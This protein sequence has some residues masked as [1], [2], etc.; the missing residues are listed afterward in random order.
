MA[1]TGTTS[2]PRTPRAAI[3]AETGEQ[4][5]TGLFGGS[6]RPT[7]G[8]GAAGKRVAEDMSA[9]VEAHVA[10][11]KAELQ[12]GIK[13]KGAGAGAFG[14]AGAMGWLGLQ[15]LFITLGFVLAIWLQAWAA[16][17]IVTG[18][19]LLLAGMAALVGR[20][21]MRTPVSLDQT[22]A[23]LTEDVAVVK[24]HLP[25]GGSSGSGGAA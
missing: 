20:A 17:A 18:L 8:V 1:A 14:A 4:P 6:A 10:L 5:R 2:G 9:L 21:K 24:S 19:L 22:K 12:E 11:A 23:N 3:P 13:A 16:A 25:R 15:G 7:I